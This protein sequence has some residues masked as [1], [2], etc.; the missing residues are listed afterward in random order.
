MG[1]QLHAEEHLL[2]HPPS[3]LGGPGCGRFPHLN[4]SPLAPVRNHFSGEGKLYPECHT[5]TRTRGRD[6]K[7]YTQ[8]HMQNILHTPPVT[9]THAHTLHTN[10]HNT[11]LPRKYSTNP[12]QAHIHPHGHMHPHKLRTYSTHVSHNHTCMCTLTC[13]FVCTHMNNYMHMHA[14]RYFLYSN[15]IQ[16]EYILQTKFV[17]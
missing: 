4:L 3:H 7:N 5:H 1:P 8:V 16:A 12:T 15:L 2:L 6:F 9:C 14:H 13:I 11:Q 17:M 10:T